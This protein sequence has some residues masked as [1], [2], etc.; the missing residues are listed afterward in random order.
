MAVGGRWRSAGLR[1]GLWLLLGGW[2]GAWC[3]FAFSVAPTAF[4]VVPAQTAGGLVGPVITSLH[5]FGAAAGLALALLA[6]GL[7][8]GLWHQL[9]PLLAAGLC[10][11]SELVVTPEIDRLR[12][13][14]FGPEGNAAATS[15][16]WHLHGVSM[17]IYSAVG[18]LVLALVALHAWSDAGGAE[19]PRAAPTIPNPA[20]N[21]AEST[22]NA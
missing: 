12:E 22:K 6:R 3:L 13:L 11:Y 18:L 4:R 7:G 17:G 16:F 8:R 15:R 9:L 1:G 21:R 19:A 14:A 5:L 10:L 2:F 20:K